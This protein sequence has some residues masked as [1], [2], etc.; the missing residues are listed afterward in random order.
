MNHLLDIRPI[1]PAVVNNFLDHIT[2]SLGYCE[3][4]R[5]CSNTRASSPGLGSD[6]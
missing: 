4:L 1:Q 3:N 5:C 6:S 2:H